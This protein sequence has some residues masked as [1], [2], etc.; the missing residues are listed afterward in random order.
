LA[1]DLGVLFNR[2]A[3]SD[4]EI[5]EADKAGKLIDIAPP[6]D[7][8]NTETSKAGQKHPILSAKNPT[9]LKT[10][11]VPS[12]TPPPIAPVEPAP[13]V[14][15]KQAV[16]KNQALKPGGPTSGPSPGAGRILNNILKP[17]I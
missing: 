5:M 15:S 11:P 16:Q 4:Q 1:G 3:I 17:V 8:V 2:M 9:G 13:P 14:S 6:F 10:A 7:V 12:L